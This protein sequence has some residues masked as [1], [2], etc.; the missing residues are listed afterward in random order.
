V[1]ED[2]TRVQAED[3][4]FGDAGVGAADPDCSSLLSATLL[5]KMP[6]CSARVVGNWIAEGL[7]RHTDLG[8]LAICQFLKETRV[9][10]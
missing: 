5:P 1:H 7:W 8:R 4:G 3:R 6:S 9:L 10:M 2:V